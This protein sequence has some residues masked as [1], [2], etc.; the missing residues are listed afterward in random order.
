MPD[1]QVAPEPS[2]SELRAQLRG[3]AEVAHETEPPAADASLTAAPAKPAPAPEPEAAAQ[4]PER[5][6]D[7]DGKFKSAIKAEAKVED[8]D[9]PVPAGVQKRIDKAVRAQRQ[10]ERERDEALARTGSQPA[11]EKAQPAAATGKP[12]AAKFETY[13]AY[14]EALTD[15]KIE[16]RDAARANAESARSGNRAHDARVA[17]VKADPEYADYDEVVKEAATMRISQVMHAAIRESDAGPKL[18]Y[19]LAQHQD[20]AARIA[21][22]SPTAG[23]MA[24]G[25]LAAQLSTKAPVKTDAP[26]AAAKPPL[27]RPAKAV[28]G[29]AAPHVVDLDD[30]KLPFDTFK[31]EM[32]KLQAA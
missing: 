12:D 30:P 32:R 11:T 5:E 10:A 9:A 13:E 31:R 27:P 19:Y 15:W 21:G 8:E 14:V 17:A 4:E 28:G 23:A 25:A 29:G 1:D 7:A 22:L 24:M 3:G 16:S 18:A 2:I 26:V 20:E 6:R